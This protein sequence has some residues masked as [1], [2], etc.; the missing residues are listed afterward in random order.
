MDLMFI[1][2]IEIAHRRTCI[3]NDFGYKSRPR[4]VSQW[5]CYLKSILDKVMSLL[6]VSLTIT[7]Q[8][9]YFVVSFRRLIKLHA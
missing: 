6:C 3:Q 1:A 8:K 4:V 9:I 7:G 5:V 2:V